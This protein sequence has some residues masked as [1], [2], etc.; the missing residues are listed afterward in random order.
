[1]A[2]QEGAAGARPDRDIQPLV[3]ED[4]LVVRVHPELLEKTKLPESLV[5]KQIWEERFE[6]I[7]GFERY[8]A[9]N[10][11]VILKFFLHV[12]RAEQK[13]R[14]LARLEEPAKNWK[15]STAD[16]AERAHWNDYGATRT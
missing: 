12:S 8:L 5:T 6:D 16:A 9:R 7:C 10:G 11:Y 4:V 2:L 13:R 14:F 1:V 15:F 3:L